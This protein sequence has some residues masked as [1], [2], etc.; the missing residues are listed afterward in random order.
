[1]KS[2]SQKFI[3]KYGWRGAVQMVFYPVVALVTNPVR[4]GQTLWNC[5]TLVEGKSWADFP[6]FMP[7]SAL[8]SLFYRTRA[9]NISRYG[10]S[11]QSP[12]LG[13]GN[14]DLTRTFYYSL[15]SLYLYSY[16]G[17]VTLLAGM[18]GWWSS[19]LLWLQSNASVTWAI[20]VLL[21]ALCS[22][23]F[24]ANTFA[25]QNYNVL[26][27]LFFPLVLFS[28]GTQNWSL[29]VLAML[30]MSF[31]SLTTVVIA[32]MLAGVQSVLQLSPYPLLTMVPAFVKLATHV[33]PLL[34]KGNLSSIIVKITKAIGMRK[35]DAK[36]VRKEVTKLDIERL[37][38][39]LLY[40][41]FACTFFYLDGQ[42]PWLFVFSLGLWLANATVARFADEQTFEMLLFSIA[43]ATLL[44]G[45]A[46]HWLLLVSYWLVVSP[47]FPF[48]RILERSHFLI[49]P[50]LKP[51][52]IHPILKDLKAFLDPVPK[53]GRVLMAFSDPKGKYEE[54]FDRYRVI[55]E[56]IHFV[57][58]KMKIHFIPDWWG[59]FELNYEGAPD[60]WGRDVEEVML[61]LDYWQAQYLII[62]QHAGTQLDRKWQ[63][64]GFRQL[65]HFSWQ[66][67]ESSFY[68]HKPYNT[69]TPDWW[70]LTRKPLHKTEQ[71][72]RENTT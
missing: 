24:F 62:Y 33:V 32:A 37:Y 26:G 71:K 58:N 70:L 19:H 43:T 69:V 47:L 27:W 3:E 48:G 9:L 11:G 57:A 50:R 54:I 30:G 4:L 22:S 2:K 52:N 31:A 60:F 8:N 16:A 44:Q 56:V 59:I 46:H 51:Y 25:K 1:M 49:L 55:V 28:W 53:D 15:P 13:L 21:L 18:F 68:P 72:K 10:V 65:S 34:A 6:H 61:N 40:L 20:V 38:K 39:I 67:Y 36:Y 42:V 29:A 64:A 66:R 12:Y 7:R 41:Q 14:Y 63:Q 23:T 45:H 5:R 35:R 17:A